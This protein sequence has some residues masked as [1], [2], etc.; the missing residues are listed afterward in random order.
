MSK[1][2]PEILSGR[3]LGIEEILV[4][5]N[6][7]SM[8]SIELF[9]KAEEIR[10]EF[11][12]NRVYLRGLIEISNICK[13][14]CYYCGIRS[15]NHK[16]KRYELSD[17]EIIEA[18]LIAHKNGLASIALQS[19]EIEN[20]AFTARISRLL[21]KI[22]EISDSQL[23]IT[24]ALGEQSEDVY[25]E[26]FDAGARRYLLRIETSDRELY[27]R[28]HP[29]DSG[30]SFNRRVECLK[31]LQKIGYQTG[32]GVMIGLPFQSINDL[33]HDIIFM[34]GLD[35]D[36]VGM[37]PYIEHPLTPLIEN[38]SHLMSKND[39]LELSLKMI[40]VMRIV[41]KDINIV[42]ATA[43]DAIDP[44]GREKALR[45]GANIIMP[46]ITPEQYNDSYYLYD[47]KPSANDSDGLS[48]KDSLIAKGFEIGTGEWG[49]SQHFLRRG[50][51]PVN[52]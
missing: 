48:L 27:G 3:E 44:N 43:L 2:I 30:H 13:K 15:G 19:G 18:A 36:M 10:R 50:K 45:S 22:M 46:N 51:G 9:R 12:G 25:K 39:R 52:L 16:V 17:K 49:D 31:S 26:W 40:A 6:S 4:L 47:G 38:K 29:D 14:N 42:A 11:V 32:T 24:L 41:M 1:S 37:G 8:E 5:L 28:L 23:G 20:P 33:A 21:K 34:R 35:I 7:S